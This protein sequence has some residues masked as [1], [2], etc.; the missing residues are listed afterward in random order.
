[1]GSKSK[2]SRPPKVSSRS[3]S[4]L[5]GGVRIGTAL[6][7]LIFA[8]A[9]AAALLHLRPP[10]AAATVDCVVRLHNPTPKEFAA[11]R[12]R[13]VVLLSGLSDNHRKHVW[14]AEALAS[15]EASGAPILPQ[16]VFALAKSG[17]SRREGTPTTLGSYVASLGAPNAS[18]D[19]MGFDRDFFG[20]AAGKRLL[21]SLALS[22]HARMG[23][24]TSSAQLLL[25]VGGEGHGL[26]F[27]YHT[28]SWLELLTGAKRCTRPPPFSHPSCL[29]CHGHSQQQQQQR[30]PLP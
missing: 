29:L 4:S 8:A 21:G 3:N 9:V 11:H 5:G 14:T 13:S 17:G 25:S 20:T 18:D 12:G 19:V 26:P 22:G 15:G 27:H 10:A 16:S 30:Q 7:V 24:D 1:M 6:A 28:A 2:P 23:L